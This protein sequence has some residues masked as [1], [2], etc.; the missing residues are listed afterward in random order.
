MWVS[1]FWGL[2]G[3]ALALG[4]SGL[5]MIWTAGL[6]VWGQRFLYSSTFFFVLSII[7]LL[8]PLFKRRLPV[9]LIQPDM[10]LSDVTNY[11]VNDSSVEL[12]KPMP[13]EIARF[14]AAKGHLINWP[15]IGHQDALTRVQT[16]L[17]NGDLDSWGRREI[18]PN[19]ASF[20]SSLRPIPKE[21]WLTACIH[22]L[23]CFH[24]TD[25]AQT[26]SLPNRNVE[27][28]TSLTLN[29]RQVKSLWLPGPVW[30]KILADLRIIRRRN[31]F[32]KRLDAHYNAIE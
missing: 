1:N 29:K 4:L 2:I 21:Y 8:W 30:R 5:S 19:S 32:G 17:N 13:S 25:Q 26:T 9:S 14:G 22:P 20:E 18:M 10:P 6:E 31:Y 28:Y 24:S 12:K 11:M 15:G 7:C 3:I 23:F 27:R 16:A